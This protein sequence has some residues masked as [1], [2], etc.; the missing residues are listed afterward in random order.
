[1]DRISDLLNRYLENTCTRQEMDELLDH[2][3]QN[4]EDERVSE[5]FHRAWLAEGLP[6][7]EAEHDPSR[8]E[9]KLPIEQKESVK[10][11]MLLKVAA[12]IL[13]LVA[14]FIG[15]S[16]WPEHPSAPF[17]ENRS[18]PKDTVETHTNR[19]IVLAD[20]SKVWIHKNSKLTY[21]SF[22][23]DTREVTLEGEAFFD[24]EPDPQRPFIIKTGKVKTTVLGTSFNIRAFASEREVTV[25]VARG[26]V[27]VETDDNKSKSITA[28]QQLTLNLQS[29]KIEQR[30][31]DVDAVEV[32]DWTKDDLILH[33]VTFGEVEEILEE[34]FSVDIRFDNPLIKTCRFTTTFFQE[35]SMEEVIA[36]IC[37][38]NGASYEMSDNDN[39][40]TVYG[41]G[42]KTRRPYG[43]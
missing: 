15:Y 5:A 35:G 29:E 19:L 23:G 39:I 13:V 31:V 36:A 38:V 3:K 25:T 33:E 17:A 21:P 18:A 40:I 12:S 10:R 43:N 24:V 26:K 16:L 32:M 6:V 34:R 20:R 2:I 14:C 41:E 9:R 30:A 7:G 11:G 27:K 8:I 37:L 1:M 28:N 4:P 42:C 22:N